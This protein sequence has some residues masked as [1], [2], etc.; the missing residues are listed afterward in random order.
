MSHANRQLLMQ[1][2]Y[3]TLNNQAM[4]TINSMSASRARVDVAH[5]N[6]QAIE[7]FNRNRDKMAASAIPQ[8]RMSPVQKMFMQPRNHIK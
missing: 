3:Q 1:N 6:S 2:T 7:A 4:H 8:M 5:S